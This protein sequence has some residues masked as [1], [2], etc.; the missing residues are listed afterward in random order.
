MRRFIPWIALVFALVALPLVALAL[1]DEYGLSYSS[2]YPVPVSTLGGGSIVTTAG[3]GV[4]VVCN[5]TPAAIDDTS[6]ANTSPRTVECCNPSTNTVTVRIGGAAVGANA[7]GT[8]PS[9]CKTV[10]LAASAVLGCYAASATTIQC[11]EY[12]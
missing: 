5:T 8:E 6:I 9:I 2:A 3:T 4:A 10:P 12:N 7:A 1:Q 11:T